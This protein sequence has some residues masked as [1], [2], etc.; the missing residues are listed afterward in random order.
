MRR[1]VGVSIGPPKTSIAPNPTSSQTIIRT[2]GAPSGA[3]GCR[4]GSQSGTES[5][6]ST[7]TTPLNGFG[8]ALPLVVGQVLRTQPGPRGSAD[9]PCG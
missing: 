7:L 9:H 1:I 2:L 8:M 6:M 4:N 3:F 5:R